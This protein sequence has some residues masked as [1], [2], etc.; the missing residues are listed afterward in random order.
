MQILERTLADLTAEARALAA[1]PRRILGI[2]GPPGAG[3]STLAAALASALGPELAVVVSMDG[4]HLANR[5]LGQL[6]RQTR[7]GAIDT[8]DDGGYAALLCRLKRQEPGDP[9]IYAPEFDRTLEEPIGSAVP[10]RPDV[11]LVITEGN[12]LLQDSGS[13]PE[14]R[15][16]LDAV[17]YLSLAEPV[18]M[19]RLAARHAAF[20]KSPEEARRWAQGS[21]QMNADL[22][23]A[24]AHTADAVLKLTP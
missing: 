9:V 18:R 4:F 14:A 2:T 21:D 20:G 10:V 15:K 3:K 8:F 24:R 12:Y 6:G 17:W 13:W 1:G 5:I 7:K 22:V 23:A 11:P 19:Q 16:Q